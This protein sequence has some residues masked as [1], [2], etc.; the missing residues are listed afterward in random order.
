MVAGAEARLGKSKTLRNFLD[1]L[2]AVLAG[3]AIYFLIMPHLPRAIQHTYF[4][5]DWGL[6]VDFL[7]CTIIFVAL[8]LMRSRERTSDE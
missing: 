4:K 3:N 8:K 5:E 6:M 7:I 2:L 1:A